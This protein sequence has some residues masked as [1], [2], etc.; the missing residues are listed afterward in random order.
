MDPPTYLKEGD[1]MVLRI[2]GLGE[3]RQKVVAFDAWTARAAAG[4]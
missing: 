1:E 4:A 3:Q 2:E